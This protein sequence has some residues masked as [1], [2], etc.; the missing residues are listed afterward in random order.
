ML[1]DA[2][3]EMHREHF[4]DAIN[5]PQLDRDMDLP[6]EIDL[7]VTRTRKLNH[8]IREIVDLWSK[9]MNEIRAQVRMLVYSLRNYKNFHSI[10][11][12]F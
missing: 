6:S 5:F 4:N 12:H 10:F 1:K 11:I 7:V 8:I 3:L 2:F 9:T